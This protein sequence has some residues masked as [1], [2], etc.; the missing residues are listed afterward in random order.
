MTD[1]VGELDKTAQPATGTHLLDR[2]QRL[3]FLPTWRFW[4]DEENSR[5]VKWPVR[6]AIVAAFIFAIAV[7]AG[8]LV[9]GLLPVLAITITLGLVE[10]YIRRRVLERRAA[11]TAEQS[12]TASIE[13]Q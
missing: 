5:L 4:R 9:A 7:D 6:L 11:Q 2:P 10:R 12:G 13:H 3:G 8:W 1:A